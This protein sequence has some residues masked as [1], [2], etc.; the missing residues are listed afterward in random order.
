MKGL[1]AA[2]LAEVEAIQRVVEL[3]YEVSSFEDASSADPED[4]RAPFT[5]TATLGYTRGEELVTSSV[6]EYVELR[7]GLLESGDLQSLI[8]WELHGATEFF[9]HVAHRISSYAVRVN[10]ADDLA[11]R[12]VMSFQLMKVAGDW[13]VHS[14]VWHAES[15][16]T[17]LTARYGGSGFT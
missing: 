7:R 11:E 5:E 12:G 4:F 13:K 10:G 14:L 16:A 8:E 15:E 17:P 3:T 9:G 2:E 1:T 6:D